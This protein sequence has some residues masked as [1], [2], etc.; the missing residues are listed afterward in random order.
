M[1]IPK[2]LPRW[3]F[4][5][6]AV[7][8]APT[9]APTPASAANLTAALAYVPRQAIAV[10]TVDVD[11]LRRVPLFKAQLDDL[12]LQ[13]PDAKRERDAL[14]KA[15]GFDPVRDLH[16][17]VG[18]LGPNFERDDS[19]FVAIAQARIN[20]KRLVAYLKTK[21]ADV[22]EVR[23]RSGRHYLL[24]EGLAL[25]FRGPLVL[26]GGKDMVLSALTRK[27]ADPKLKKLLSPFVLKD[28][29]FAA[30]VPERLR[31]DARREMAE[32]G[33]LENVRGGIDLQRGLDLDVRAGF[34][35][36]TSAR[37]VGRTAN[38]FLDRLRQETSGGGFGKFA[39][40]LRVQTTG[41][42]LRA[43]LQ[44]SRAEV[45]ELVGLLEAL[46]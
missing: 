22:R 6:L 18:A 11:R 8:L 40:K 28:L 7:L 3:L 42:D 4:L 43:T 34:T 17:V 41:V 21:G 35:D 27:G 19:D 10:G 25:A 5:F 2:H 32:L 38:M 24:D 9:V 45:E 33:A 46:M 37:A 1:S 20:E 39:R 14:Q 15:T 29:A 44:L 31:R 30:L 13:V 23:G 12:F 36:P 16:G 26:A